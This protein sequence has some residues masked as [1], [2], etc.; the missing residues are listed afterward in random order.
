MAW[1]IHTIWKSLFKEGLTPVIMDTPQQMLDTLFTLYLFEN[2][3]S[4]KQ[5]KVDLFAPKS[6]AIIIP[7]TPAGGTRKKKTLNNCFLLWKKNIISWRNLKQNK[8]Q[9]LA[10]CTF[11]TV[12]G[13]LCVTFKLLKN[14]LLIQVLGREKIVRYFYI[15]SQLLI[16]SHRLFCNTKTC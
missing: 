7:D 6:T 13:R 9:N 3:S 8:N 14:R 2:K 12:R 5:R 1:N 16:D 10:L 4:V 11:S 15:F